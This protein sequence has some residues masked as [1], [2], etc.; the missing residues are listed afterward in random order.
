MRISLGQNSSGV[1]I[2]GGLGA[3]AVVSGSTSSPISAGGGGGN[4]GSIWSPSQPA[5]WV[6]V[7][8]VLAFAWLLLGGFAFAE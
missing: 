1:S 8:M 3:A 6:G 2:G 4:L 7:A 5:F